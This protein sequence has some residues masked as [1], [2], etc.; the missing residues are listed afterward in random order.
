MKIKLSN[1]KIKIHKID[2]HED[3][4]KEIDL[5]LEFECDNKTEFLD[6]INDSKIQK[7]LKIFKGE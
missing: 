6:F 2:Y 1:I 3:Y 5:D 4:N 7:V